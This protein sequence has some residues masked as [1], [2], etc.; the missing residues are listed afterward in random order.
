MP[1]EVGGVNADAVGADQVGKLLRY[2]HARSTI[3]A[4]P[5]PTPMHIVASP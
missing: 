3:V 2:R 4:M 5:C 1:V